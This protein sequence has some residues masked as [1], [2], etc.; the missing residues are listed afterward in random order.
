MI[1]ALFSLSTPTE[2]RLMAWGFF[3]L[4]ILLCILYTKRHYPSLLGKSLKNNLP[5][6]IK[7]PTNNATHTPKHTN[8][9]AMLSG[10]SP[11]IKLNIPLNIA[12]I[13]KSVTTKAQ[14]Q[15]KIRRHIPGKILSY[16]KA[17]NQLRFIRTELQVKWL[18]RLSQTRHEGGHITHYHPR[19]KGYGKTR[20]TLKK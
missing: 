11:K 18:S 9:E 8:H 13:T 1:T 4:A 10:N 15:L 16:T 17:L 2:V 7:E 12:L 3:S 14:I 5:N 19:L 6:A 20:K